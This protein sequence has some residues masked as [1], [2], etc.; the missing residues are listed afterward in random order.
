M[1]YEVERLSAVEL[2]GFLVA[3]L[4]F[5]PPHLKIRITGCV[6]CLKFNG[7]ESSYQVL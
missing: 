7:M 2:L 5:N 1:V 3:L 6:T 4:G